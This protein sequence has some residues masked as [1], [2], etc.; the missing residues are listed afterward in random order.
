MR[1][2]TRK[3]LE[4][5]YW[6][7]F[8]DEP[9]ATGSPVITPRLSDPSFLFPDESPD[10]LWHLFAHT[11]Q[12]IEHYTSTSGLE[13]KREHLLF[14]R[15][16]SPFIYKEGSVYYLLYEIHD[17]MKQKGMKRRLTGSRIMFS[18]SSDLLLWSEPR[19][20][21]DAA[22]VPHTAYRGGRPR[23][24]RPQL[25]RTGSRYRLY[26]GAG[27]DRI[28][29]TGQKA[30][31]YLMAA[32]SS[33]P[34]GPYTVI[35]DPLISPDPES[36]YRSLATGSVRIIP[37]SDGIAALECAYYYDDA[38]KKSR[39]LMRL[40]FSDDGLSWEDS[41]IIQKSPET[42]WASRYI[43][44]CDVRYKENE[45][46]WYCYYSANG[47]DRSLHLPVVTESLGLLLGK[48]K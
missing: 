47:I 12:G 45:D 29:D 46:T 40:L 23:V 10:S 9:I 35:P 48:E 19:M 18:S 30:S 27:E 24:S 43:S 38:D 15:G 14:L 32:E 26:F 31:A 36:R 39:S 22:S 2:R 8:N 41:T 7:S 34:D 16:H 5:T 37:L 17:A 25:I 44:S 21:L 28:Y 42:G 1:S 33:S 3:A 6:Y 4:D 13:W 11:W 20:I